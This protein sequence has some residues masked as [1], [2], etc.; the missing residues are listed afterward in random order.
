MGVVGRALL[1][2][3]GGS[4]ASSLDACVGH[5]TVDHA[6][7]SRSGAVPVVEGAVGETCLVSSSCRAGG[8]IVFDDHLDTVVVCFVYLNVWC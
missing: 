4:R 7:L 1:R 6:S 8:D 2:S 3:N 5:S